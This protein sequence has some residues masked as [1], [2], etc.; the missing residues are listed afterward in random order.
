MIK[1]LLLTAIK[2]YKKALSPYL[3]RS[4]RYLP[5]CSDYAYDAINNFGSAKGVLL[6]IWRIIR[7]NPLSRGG[8]DPVIKNKKNERD[9]LWKKD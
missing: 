9:Y 8:Y 7:C 1:K 5:T 6:S 2:A 3:T 4:C